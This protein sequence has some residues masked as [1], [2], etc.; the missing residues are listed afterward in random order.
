MNVLQGLLPLLSLCTIVLLSYACLSANVVLCKPSLNPEIFRPSN[1]SSSSSS[2][3]SNTSG[4]SSACCMSS[5]SFSQPDVRSLLNGL[6]LNMG[7]LSLGAESPQ[8]GAKAQI[9]YGDIV[10]DIVN[11][12]TT[13]VGKNNTGANSVMSI[14]TVYVSPVVDK[15]A[16]KTYPAFGLLL[17]SNCLVFVIVALAFMG[18]SPKAWWVVLGLTFCA[19]VFLSTTLGLLF[20]LVP[21]IDEKVSLVPPVLLN[22]SGCSVAPDTYVILGGL[23]TMLIL[24]GCLLRDRFSSSTV[25]MYMPV[26]TTG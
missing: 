10:S 20:T 2:S 24:L 13:L 9:M 8:Y 22:S 1:R 19:C 4:C 18:Q 16:T 15:I 5:S 12:I 26:E 11:I 14:I 17:A 6:T 23:L 7:F 21:Y 25:K 3:S